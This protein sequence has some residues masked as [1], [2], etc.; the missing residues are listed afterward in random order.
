MRDDALLFQIA[1]MHFEEGFSQ[2]EVAQKLGL[3]RAKVN[4]LLQTAKDRGIVRVLVVP[5]LGHAYLRGIEDDLKAAYNLQDVLLIPGREGIIKGQLNLGTQEAIVERLAHAAAE[6]LDRQLTDE[7][8]LCINWGRVMR[9][10]VDHLHPSK[11]LSGLKVLPLLGNLSAQPDS[12]EANLLAQ[13]VALAYG[14]EFSWLIA[15]AIVRNLQQQEVVRALPLVQTTLAQISQATIAITAIGHADA[16]HS[17]VVKRGWLDSAE[18]EALIE[19]GAVGEICS[20][21]FD[22]TGREIRDDK[23]YPIG[24]GLA[25]LK[26][27]VQEG[28]KVIAVVGADRQRLEPVRVALLSRLVNILIS[29]HITAQYL[30]SQAS[31]AKFTNSR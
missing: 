1:K 16:K 18:I 6:Y 30:L 7:D 5:K 27:M 15:P 4:R 20:W 19:A 25:G 17:T 10:V 29:D 24:L 26:K 13:E 12:F 14:A 22:V 31:S 11:T 21:W 28:K 8:T 9:A 2:G 23:I 3:S